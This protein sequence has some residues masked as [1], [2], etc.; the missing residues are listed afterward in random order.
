MS[1]GASAGQIYRA[2]PLNDF[3]SRLGDATNGLRE[4]SCVG[5]SQRFIHQRN[6]A[7]RETALRHGGIVY[8]GFECIGRRRGS[9]QGRSPAAET[10]AG[11]ILDPR[12][13][14][15]DAARSRNL[16][17][18]ALYVPCRGARTTSRRPMCNGS[19][20]SRPT[21]TNRCSR[22]A[23]HP[24]STVEEVKWKTCVLPQSSAQSALVRQR[25]P[26]APG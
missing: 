18:C 3:R 24:K 14:L 12:P 11:A 4:A 20:C 8:W 1:H 6:A 25:S 21:D 13:T 5:R 22:F 15:A 26:S 23:I 7:V 17:D 9:R 19:G 2:V 10:Y 16:C